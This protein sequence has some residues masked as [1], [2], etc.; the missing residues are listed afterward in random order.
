MTVATKL[1]SERGFEDV[2]VREIAK[3]SGQNLSM[4]SY[5]FGG[6]EGLYVAIL[7]EHMQ[8]TI[9]EISKIF[10]SADVK[11]MTKQTFHKEI[12]SVVSL[13]TNLKFASPEMTN[14][15]HRERINR[16]PYAREI[17]EKLTTPVVGQV[18]EVFKQ[19]QKKGIVRSN[20]DPRVFIA[21]LFESVIGYFA[22]HECGIKSFQGDW[23]FPRDKEKFIDFITDLFLQG[24][25]K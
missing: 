25:F 22:S 13:V 4:I 6:K 14:I 16:L 1:F 18:V 19:A 20:F 2:S 17:H 21:V 9:A 3:A 11:K 7:Q 12:R 10:S 8:K 23:K 24:I 15:M 5:Y